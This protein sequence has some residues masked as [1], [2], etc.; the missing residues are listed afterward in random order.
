MKIK[1]SQKYV[2]E[3]AGIVKKCLLRDMVDT[4]QLVVYNAN[5]NT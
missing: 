3:D 2:L 4:S 5:L 1:L